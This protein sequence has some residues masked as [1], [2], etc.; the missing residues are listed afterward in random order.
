[1]GEGMGAG[2][3]RQ[4]GRKLRRAREKGM[5][6][7]HAVGLHV[8]KGRGGSLVVIAWQRVKQPRGAAQGMKGGG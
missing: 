6:L 2:E 1:M 4:N 8:E 7:G 3:Q 5:A